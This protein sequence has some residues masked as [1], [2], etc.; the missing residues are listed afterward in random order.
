[1]ALSS[2]EEEKMP[3]ADPA[4][5]TKTC[6]I[7]VTGFGPF[8]GVPENPTNLMVRDLPSFLQG[9]KTGNG[10]E[11]PSNGSWKQKVLGKVLTWRIVETSAQGVREALD[12]LETAILAAND[13][14]EQKVFVLHMGVNINATGFQLERCAYND[15]T[16][17]IPDERGYQPTK[18]TILDPSGG[19]ASESSD[20]PLG[21]RLDTR[22]PVESWVERLSEA[23]PAIETRLSTDPGRFVCNY[24]YCSSLHRLQNCGLKTDAPVRSD[25]LG[26][27]LSLFLHVPSFDLVPQALQMEYIAELMRL[28]TEER[29]D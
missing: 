3:F 12:D 16:F 6:K 9:H 11:R 23:F 20:P 17:R 27:T 10:N 2:T 28:M 18:E 25:C 26:A 15:A 8:G 24:L 19:E 7:L 1:M 4:D 13:G 5:T 29:L 14:T 22:C 21:A